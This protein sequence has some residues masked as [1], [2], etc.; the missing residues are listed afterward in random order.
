MLI[1]AGAI[2]DQRGEDGFTPLAGAIRWNKVDCA[3]YL[4]DAGAKMS[5]VST[6]ISIPAW[7]KDIIAK[8]HNVKRTLLAFI[9]VLRKR[10]S[11]KWAASERI[12]NR[13]PRDIVKLLAKCVW[14]TRFD[15]KWTVPETKA[16]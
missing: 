11:I 6:D 4:L 9:G 8:R 13:L 2:I 5:D 3:E 14:G 12:A 7:M 16:L 1:C 15:G 10:F